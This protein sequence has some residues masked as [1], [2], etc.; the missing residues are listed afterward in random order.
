[1]TGMVLAMAMTQI[2]RSLTRMEMAGVMDMSNGL[3]LIWMTQTAILKVGVKG[4]LN[5]YMKRCGGSLSGG[6]AGNEI[7][8]AISA[9]RHR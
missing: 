5:G 2:G 1:M 7:Q 8:A 3:A 6:I 9:Q 4:R